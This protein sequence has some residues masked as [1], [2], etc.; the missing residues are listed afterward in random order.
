[1]ARPLEHVQCERGWEGVLNGLLI[2]IPAAVVGVKGDCSRR[3]LRPAGIKRHHSPVGLAQVVD[4]FPV[5]VIDAGAVR[6][7]VPAKEAV[8]RAGKAVGGK[9][10]GFIIDKALVR[11]GAFPAVG[12]KVHRVS[13][14]GP[15]GGIDP[16]PGG[17]LRKGDGQLRLS[18]SG[19]TPAG[20]G[21]AVTGRVDEGDVL[22]FNGVGCRIGPVQTSAF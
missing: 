18:G 21:I 9:C 7:R 5:T 17:A 20:E 10:P 13:D 22:T 14:G 4:G 6:F 1:M 16:V 2:L 19:F 3:V 12:V 11:H 15:L 8:P